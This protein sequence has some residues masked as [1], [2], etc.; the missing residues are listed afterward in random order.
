MKKLVLSLLTL[1]MA[2]AFA[3]CAPAPAA[4]QIVKETVIVPQTVVVAAT[5]AASAPA[6]APT[7]APAP[8]TAAAA[9][10]AAPAAAGG[11]LATVLNRKKLVCGINGS[12]VGFSSLAPNGDYVGFDADFCRAAAAALFGDV[13]AIEFRKLDTTARFA[14]LQSGEVD[15]VFRNTT[16]TLGRDTQNGVDF[17]PTTFYDGGGMLVPKKSNIT[18]LEQLNGA[19]ICVLEGTTNVQV[20][21]DV[22]KARN[23]KYTAQTFKDAETLYKSLDEGR[24]DAATSDKSQLAGQRAS[25][26]KVPGDYVILDETM[27]KEPLTP[28]VGQGDSIWRDAM[29]YVVY[30][31]FYAEEAGITSKNVDDM[32]KSDDPNL[33]NFFGLTNDL[34][35]K[36]GLNNDA[37]YNVVK[38]V[39]NYGE[40]YDR[41]LTPLG[42]PRGL[43]A[44]YTKGG[45]LYAPPLRP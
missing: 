19:T 10:T 18:K 17:L 13:K 8:T 28:M 16:V 41:N 20:L 5:S 31:T 42:I 22:F 6:S 23:I 45:V 29:S 40:I 35:K 27:S 43:N 37:F 39:G 1:A 15:I 9:A 44:L 7:T 24:C 32:K 30:A 2:V 12:L 33:K 11:R 36:M 3:A 26:V 21:A 34:P 14:A 4:P 25:L 38:L